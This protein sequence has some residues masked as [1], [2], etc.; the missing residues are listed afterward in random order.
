MPNV[1]AVLVLLTTAAIASDMAKC[2]SFADCKSCLTTAEDG[3]EPTDAALCAWCPATS[4]CMALTDVATTAESCPNLLLG[5]DGC[6]CS[7]RGDQCSNCTADDSCAYI[8][9]DSKRTVTLRVDGRPGVA[10]LVG[11]S[12]V[13]WHMF[14]PSTGKTTRYFPDGCKMEK[15]WDGDRQRDGGAPCRRTVGNTAVVTNR[16][17][18]ARYIEILP[19]SEF[20]LMNGC[21]AGSFLSGTMNLL[22]SYW[23]IAVFLCCWCCNV[24]GCSTEYILFDLCG[25]CLSRLFTNRADSSDYRKM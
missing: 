2:S 21:D 16:S 3:K 6:S 24:C 18:T 12:C 25:C 22:Q 1:M 23:W 4:V 15:R 17:V 7:Q 13:P 5:V 8:P 14:E 11:Q 9:A 19:D 10:T 20:Y